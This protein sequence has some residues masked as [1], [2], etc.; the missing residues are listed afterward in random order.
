MAPAQQASRPSL[1]LAALRWLEALRLCGDGLQPLD[2]LLQ[3][4]VFL[5][6]EG[7][8]PGQACLLH[9][10]GVCVFVGGGSPSLGLAG[11]PPR[12]SAPEPTGQSG[13]QQMLSSGGAQAHVP[14]CPFKGAQLAPTA[15]VDGG[16][17]EGKVG[18]EAPGPAPR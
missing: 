10:P 14:S 18:P 8:A 9:S 3:G 7:E 4:G 15:L 1:H 2:Q 11:N 12:P 17:Q 16:V 13:L 5:G 6:G